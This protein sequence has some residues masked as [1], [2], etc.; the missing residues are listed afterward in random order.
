MK[1]E[2]PDTVSF[3]RFTELMQQ[4]LMA[5]PVLK[6]GLFGVLFRDFLHRL[7]PGKG[8]QEQANSKPEGV[9]G[10]CR[11]GAFH[12]GLVPRLQAAH[13]YKRQGG[14]TELYHNPG[15]RGR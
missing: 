9:K 12:Y 6:D 7:D 10:H 8:M 13:H 4:N 2:F 11:H 3:N 14:N 1:D 15:E 5:I